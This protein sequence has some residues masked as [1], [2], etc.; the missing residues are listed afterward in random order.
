MS[1]QMQT[2]AGE[3]DSASPIVPADAR[4][5]A[6]PP[7]ALEAFEG[8][9]RTLFSIA[10]RMLGSVREAE[11][12]LQDAYIRWHGV[13]Y[14]TVQNP[15][16]Y[17]A[18]LVTHL[19]INA[20]K[21]AHRRRVE[22]VGPWLPEPLVE[23][24][25]VEQ[26]NAEELREL[27]DELSTAFLLMLERLTPVERAIFLL[28]ESFDFSYAEIA[29]IVGKTEANCRQIERRARKHLAER[30]TPR[31]ADPA[32]HDRLLHSFLMATREGNVDQLVGLLK[33]DAVTYSD[34]GGKATAAR[35]PVRGAQNVARLFV[36]LA[37]KGAALAEDV[38]FRLARVNGET[39]LLT[40]VGGV[41]R[42]VVTIQVED[43]RIAN[44][45]VMVNPDKL[46]AIDP[47]G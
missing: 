9:R 39:G 38:T 18:R 46:P 29:G 6:R 42:N 47:N 2:I 22:Y 26:T 7:G 36:G 11:D 20:L 33:A 12:L 21:S 1:S 28:R 10:Y 14:A 32:E 35:N 30:G 25:S 8:Q 27:A 44:V 34:G 43:G 16:A 45:F 40:F 17:L 5:S 41:L 31:R 23:D 3:A 37:K 4:A 24:R 13:D 15:G 19:S